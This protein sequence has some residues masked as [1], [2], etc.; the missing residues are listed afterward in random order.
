MQKRLGNNN[1]LMYLIANGGKSAVAER[2]IKTLKG[3]IYKKIKANYS[4]YYLAY[5]NKLVDEY[6]NS[7]HGFIGKKPIDAD[8]SALTEKIG[9]NHKAPKFKVL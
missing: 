7:Y 2:F 4:K 9:L 3:E 8:Y 6:N 5:L 1:I